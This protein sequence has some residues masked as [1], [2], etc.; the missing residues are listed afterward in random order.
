MSSLLLLLLFGGMAVIG[1]GVAMSSGGGSAEPRDPVGGRVPGEDTDGMPPDEDDDLADGSGGDGSDI[2]DVPDLPAR[3]YDIGW[4]GL[5]AEEQLIVELINRARLDPEGELGRQSDGYASGVTTAPKEALAVVQTLSDAAENHSEDMD[6]RNFFA[7]TNPDGDTP[8][9]RALEE[10]HGSRYVGE[11]I[12]WI[13][14]TRTSFD[15]Q[16]RAEN[17]HDN[18]WESDG[19]QR[20]FMSDNWSE[21]GVGYDYG[22]YLGY[23]GSTF[24]TEMFSDRGETYLTGVV[25]EDQDGDDFYDIGEGQGGVRVTAYDGDTAYTTATWDSGGYSLALPPGTYRVVFE[26]GDLD[27]PYETEVTI[28]SENVKLDVYDEA[29][30]AITSLSV[31]SVPDPVFLPGIE[32][33]GGNTL[34]VIEDIETDELLLV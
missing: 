32:P 12:G 2:G 8:G 1:G 5:S 17:H 22:S 20:N 3:E 15:E 21:I 6:D 4:A 10:G 26:G 28:G 23:D 14:S 9:D 18:L 27:A 13:G 19:H 29:N 34:G 16:A 31:S 25:I 33:T 30:A 7:H 11:N 24:V